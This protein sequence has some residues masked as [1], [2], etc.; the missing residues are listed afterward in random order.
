[1]HTSAPTYS[2]G[3]LVAEVPKD[4]TGLALFACAVG[5][6]LSAG[7]GAACGWPQAAADS[8]ADAVSSLNAFEIPTKRIELPPIESRKV[9]NRIAF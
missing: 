8:E 3:E 9:R 6:D 1:L 7:G 4:G 2:A 5:V